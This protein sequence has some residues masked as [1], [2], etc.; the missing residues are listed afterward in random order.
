MPVRWAA[1]GRSVAPATGSR[2]QASSR[3]VVILLV[4]AVPIVFDPSVRPSFALPKFTV[5]ALAAALLA[6]LQVGE[7]IRAPAGRRVRNGLEMPVLLLLGWTALSA[8]ASDDPGR[9]VLGGRESLDGLAALTALVV[10]FFAAARVLHRRHVRTVLSVLLFGGGGAVL[11]YAAVQLRDR[12]VGGGRWDPVAW[13]NWPSEDAVW[14]TL[15]NPN[16]LAAFVAVLLPVGLALL[17][18]ARTA[19][20]RGCTAVVVAALL[21]VLVVV[22]SRGALLGGG[23]AVL[24]TAVWLRPE[25]RARRRA[26]LLFGGALLAVASTL[27][28]VVV[29]AGPG[30]RDP[31]ALLEHDVGT[32]VHLRAELW[33]TAWRMAWEHPVLGVGPDGFAPSF[34]AFSG[35]RFVEVYGPGLVATDPHN[36]FLAHLATRG[37]PGLVA[38]LYLLLAAAVRLRAGL[39]RE[40]RPA[41]GSLHRRVDEERVLRAAVAGALL[42]HVVAASFNRREITV[43]FCFWLLLGLSCVLAERSTGPARPEEADHRDDDGQHADG[44]RDPGDDAV[45]VT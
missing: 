20:A 34:D 9:A 28:V 8:A 32:T 27:A 42:A 43:D 44:E 14:S 26:V 37:F 7:W 6:T 2:W 45:L 22:S 10:V 18:L 38:F 21:V 41:A 30:S 1:V 19:L 3:A 39:G 12:T 33:R 11:L 23:A 16:H 24:A 29:S 35:E 4:A 15:G 13:R 17:V 25:I 5:V 40:R 31:G 36:V